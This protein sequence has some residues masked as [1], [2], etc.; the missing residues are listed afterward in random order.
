M[1]K[2]ALNYIPT[3]AEAEEW[4]PSNSKHV[5][6]S[7]DILT[8]ANHIRALVESNM[9]QHVFA[10][11]SGLILLEIQFITFNSRFISILYEKN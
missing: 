9:K 11:F 5:N 8:L 1:R 3:L 2:A 10:L 6:E 7:I 4:G